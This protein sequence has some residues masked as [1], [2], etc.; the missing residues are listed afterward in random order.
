MCDNATGPLRARDVCGSL[1]CEPLAKNIE[2]TRAELKCLVKLGLLTEA[3]TGNLLQVAIAGHLR[4]ATPGHDLVCVLVIRSSVLD[5]SLGLLH[6]TCLAQQ[7]H[8]D[9]RGT[10]VTVFG[11]ATQRSLHTLLAKRPVES[12]AC[13]DICESALREFRNS[14]RTGKQS[15]LPQ[16]VV[17]YIGI[18]GVALGVGTHERDRHIPVP[19]MFRRLGLLE[20]AHGTSIVHRCAGQHCRSDR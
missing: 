15:H 16:L 19:E 14:F 11:A 9:V 18:V 6:P 12:P 8:K 17:V 2:G 20:P 7:S 3:D 1:G 4:P 13:V 5:Y 10:T